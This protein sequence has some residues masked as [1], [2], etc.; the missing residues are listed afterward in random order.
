MRRSCSRL[1]HQSQTR[2]LELEVKLT[3]SQDLMEQQCV[4]L[5]NCLECRSE[6]LK[7]Q[8][9]A[10]LLERDRYGLMTYC[11]QCFMGAFSLIVG[12]KQ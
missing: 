2:L 6:Q 12:T 5:E 3:D 9:E 8:Y 10:A 4:A 1:E 11:F 7:E